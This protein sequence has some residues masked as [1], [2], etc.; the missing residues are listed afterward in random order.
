MTILEAHAAFA[1]RDP[2]TGRDAFPHDV[3]LEGGMDAWP[4]CATAACVLAGGL[5]GAEDDDDLDELLG[6]FE[7][8][9][10]MGVT[11]DEKLEQ[12]TCRVLGELMRWGEQTEKELATAG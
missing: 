6:H 1:Q 10:N 5:E 3:T 9:V 7:S 4:A 8:L 11:S 12:E 2:F